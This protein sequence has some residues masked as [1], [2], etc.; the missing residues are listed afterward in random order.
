MRGY[1]Y[2][3]MQDADNVDHP[4]IGEAEEQEVRA[5]G[6]FPV[7]VPDVVNRA[8]LPAAGRQ[9]FAGVADTENV[10]LGLRRAPPCGGVV[11]DFSKIGLSGGG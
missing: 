5:Y 4:G 11:P 3:L 7:A 9:C 6:Q 8:A 2:P 10:A 1:V